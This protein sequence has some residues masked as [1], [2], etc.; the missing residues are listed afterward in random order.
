MAGKKEIT[1][2]GKTYQVQHPGPRW[3]LQ[4][5]DRV[6]TRGGSIQQEKYVDELLEHIVIEPKV[7]V[8]DFGNIAE[9]EEMVSQLEKFLRG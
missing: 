6:R 2:Y 3:Y 1:V 4:L 9:L 8:E 5:Q 7:R